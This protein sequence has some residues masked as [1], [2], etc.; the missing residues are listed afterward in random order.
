MSGYQGSLRATYETVLKHLG[1]PRVSRYPSR[2]PVVWFL[3]S[4]GQSISVYLS[5]EDERRVCTQTFRGIIHWHIGGVDE[6]AVAV[7]AQ[8][9]RR[10]VTTTLS[11][12][13]A[14]LT[15]RRPKIQQEAP[16]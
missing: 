15:E 16:F 1:P 9:F 13:L 2:T 10:N 3:T 8:I 4:E 6:T 12:E 11:D 7:V 14:Q 5:C